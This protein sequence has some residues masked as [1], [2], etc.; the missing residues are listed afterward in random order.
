MAHLARK[1]H[2]TRALG[3][4]HVYDAGEQKKGHKFE[5]AHAMVQIQELNEAC[6]VT[7]RRG[8]DFLI[9]IYCLCES[10]YLASPFEIFM[11]TQPARAKKKRE[12]VK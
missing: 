6:E 11:Y 10:V 5:R 8:V 1:R 12:R 7:E 9:R 3:I 4:L 2:V